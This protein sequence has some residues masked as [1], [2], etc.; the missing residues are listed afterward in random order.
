MASIPDEPDVSFGVRAQRFLDRQSP[1]VQADIVALTA[2]LFFHP[3]VDGETKTL[4]PFAS[5]EPG[6]WIYR[7][8][9]QDSEY[10]IV[11]DLEEQLRPRRLTVLDVLLATDI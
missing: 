7:R 10:I 6:R 11:Y 4:A 3:Y 1:I 8:V 9:Y 5:S 2:W